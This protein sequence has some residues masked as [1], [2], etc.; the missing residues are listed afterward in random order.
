MLACCIYSTAYLEVLVAP[1]MLFIV[2]KGIGF[3]LA[4]MSA[5]MAITTNFEQKTPLAMGIVSCGSG[6]GKHITVEYI[7]NCRFFRNVS[8]SALA[9]K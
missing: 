8:V 2:L 1:F 7:V 3:N 6:L 4:Y 9:V 5:L